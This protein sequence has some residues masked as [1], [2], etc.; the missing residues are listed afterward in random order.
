[1]ST[2]TTELF[3]IQEL[4]PNDVAFVLNDYRVI[5]VRSAREFEGPLGHLTCAESIPVS[6]VP[7]KLWYWDRDK[8]LLVVCHSGTRSERVCKILVTAGFTKVA[9][10]TG[11]M[12]AWNDACGFAADCVGG[13]P[14]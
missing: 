3:D 8:P 11:G 14:Q 2:L 1:M 6:Q 13:E 7:K 4:T 12:L 5:D 9:N 10:L